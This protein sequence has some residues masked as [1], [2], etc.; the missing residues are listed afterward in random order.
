[1]KESDH[2]QAVAAFCLRKKRP[3]P[4]EQEIGTGPEAKET[5]VRFHSLTIVVPAVGSLMNAH[6]DYLIRM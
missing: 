6:C 5:A 1:M 2:P 3:V 4:T